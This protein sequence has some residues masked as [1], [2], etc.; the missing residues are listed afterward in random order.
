MPILLSRLLGEREPEA[1]A[2]Y[3]AIV[4]R[5]RLPHWYLDGAVP[6]TTDGRFDMIAAVLATVHKTWTGE[7]RKPGAYLRGMS[8][9][10]AAGELRLG[11]TFHGLRD[12]VAIA[13]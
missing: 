7:V 6:D 12:A 10:A 5:A 1:A 9:K 11:K 2:L 13:R 8:G 4:A 3:D